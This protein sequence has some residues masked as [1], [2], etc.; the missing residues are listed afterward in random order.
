MAHFRCL[1]PCLRDKTLAYQQA[2]L[3]WLLHTKCVSA[4]HSL[5]GYQ[6]WPHLPE[7]VPDGGRPS[8][9]FYPLEKVTLRTI[10][11]SDVFNYHCY[12]VMKLF[13]LEKKLSCGT[14]PQDLLDP[15]DLLELNSML[16]YSYTS[17]M[18]R[19]DSFVLFFSKE[20]TKHTF[21][22]LWWYVNYLAQQQM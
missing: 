21:T 17:F 14:I 16:S 9:G 3:S 13:W 12:C 22:A 15:Q 18:E 5:P 4:A 11:L 8:I 1:D 2:F 6:H 19:W 10:L 20:G 7:S